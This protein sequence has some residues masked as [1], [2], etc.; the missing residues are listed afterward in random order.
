MALFSS[1][2]RKASAAASPNKRLALASAPVDMKSG[3]GGSSSLQVKVALLKVGTCSPNAAG[4][5]ASA[6]TTMIVAA[7]AG[8]RGSQRFMLRK[9]ARV[10]TENVML[11]QPA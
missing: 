4:I 11:S 8:Q 2:A 9:L 10:S 3:N 6:E 5:S 1:V 7:K